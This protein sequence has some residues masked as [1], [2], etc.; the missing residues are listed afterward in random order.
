MLLVGPF[1]AFQHV[2]ADIGDHGVGVGYEHVGIY[3]EL[4]LGV[5]S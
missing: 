5:I 1:L 2:T 3:R 4:S